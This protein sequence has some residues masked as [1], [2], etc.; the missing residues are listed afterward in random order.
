MLEVVNGIVMK[1]EVHVVVQFYVE[2]FQ[3]LVKESVVLKINVMSKF[4]HGILLQLLL[5]GLTM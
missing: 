3:V 1:I 5:Q 4:M 2:I